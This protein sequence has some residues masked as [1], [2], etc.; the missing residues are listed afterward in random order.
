M[1]TKVAVGLV[2]A[3]IWLAL[4]GGGTFVLTLGFLGAGVYWGRTLGRRDAAG[5]IERFDRW[6]SLQVELRHVERDHE[7]EVRTLSQRYRAE[8]ERIVGGP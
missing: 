8:R 5:A 3:L 1:I 2:L 4:V 6:R 7:H